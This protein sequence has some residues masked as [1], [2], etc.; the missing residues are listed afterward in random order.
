MPNFSQIGLEHVTS[1]L[2]TIAKDL[3]FFEKSNFID[4]CRLE[5][6]T[7]NPNFKR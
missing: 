5:V 1:I 7:H 6:T 3:E 2:T 4:V